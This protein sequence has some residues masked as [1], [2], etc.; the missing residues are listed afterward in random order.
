MKTL[1]SIFLVTTVAAVLFAMVGCETDSASEAT[2]SVS[3]SHVELYMGGSQEFTAKRASGYKWSVSPVGFGVLSSSSGSR[4]IYTSTANV[5]TT[6]VI[7]AQASL[8]SRGTESNE[9]TTAIQIE[10][11]GLITHLSN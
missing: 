6:V 11:F 4:V 3:P 2:I 8:I 7:T 1:C 10:G 5:A 9:T